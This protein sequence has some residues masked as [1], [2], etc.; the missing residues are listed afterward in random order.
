M[1][2]NLCQPY[3]VNFDT[4]NVLL[5]FVFPDIIVNASIQH[6]LK[7]T[8]QNVR[9]EIFDD[10]FDILFRVYQVQMIYI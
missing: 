5:C 2:S 7:Q 4:P 1:K 3:E 9:Q 6:R 10:V 8:K